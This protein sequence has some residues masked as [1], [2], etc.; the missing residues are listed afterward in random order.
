MNWVLSDIVHSH[1]Q[2]IHF[3]EQSCC[4]LCFKVQQMP[5]LSLKDK[6]HFLFV[7][8]QFL[9]IPLYC[10]HYIILKL[11]WCLLPGLD[12]KPSQGEG[13]Y[14]PHLCSSDA[15]PVLGTE[16]TSMIVKL[17]KGKL[18]CVWGDLYQTSLK[19]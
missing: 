13:Q 17:V 3:L 11:F 5:S 6:G 9:H 15:Q 8:N 4:V 2:A 18:G 14:L 19:L 12:Y 16:H 1:T 10:T 7:H